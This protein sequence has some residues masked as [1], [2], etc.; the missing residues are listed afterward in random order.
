LQK[1]KKGTQ[2]APLPREEGKKK[3]NRK[4]C[5]THVEEKKKEQKVNFVQKA[6]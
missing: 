3:K 2:P 1:E 5:N 4:P 6:L